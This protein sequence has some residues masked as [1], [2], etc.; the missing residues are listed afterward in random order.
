MDIVLLGLSIGMAN[1]LLATGIVL[2]HM[3]GRVIN[4]A[5]GELGAFA[6]AMMLSLTR[7]AHLPYPVA[8]LCSL[9]ATALLAAIIERT[10]VRRLF[11]SPRLI[12]LIGLIGVAQIIVVL[13]LIL[14]KPRVGEDTIYFGGAN[15]FPVPFKTPVW[16]FDRVVLHPQHFMALILGP[17][18]VIALSMFLRRSRYGVALRASAENAT[19][20]RS[21]GIPVQRV[22]TLAWVVAAVL[23]GI[24]SILLAPIVGFSATEAV[25]LPILMRGLAAATLARMQSVRLAF[26]WGLALGVLDQLVF[27]QTGRA[28]LTD[29]VLF[30]IVLIALLVRGREQR[31]TVASE[32]SSWDAAEPVRPLPA[33]ILT[34]PRWRGARL[35]TLAVGALLLLAAPPLLRTSTTFF[36]AA[37][38][39]IATVVVATTVLV[40]W[41]GQLSLGQWALA[42][43]GGVFGA[44]LVADFHVPFP[45][46]FVLAAAMGGLV[47]LLI[48]IPGLRIEGTGLA[49]VTLGFAIM[50]STW[51]YSQGFF[52][53]DAHFQP[54][55]YL[56]TDVHYFASLALLVG[57]FFALRAVQR[58]VLGFQIVA[59][60]DNPRQAAA[61]GVDVRRAQ[62]TAFV[63]SGIVAG[64][65]GFLWTAGTVL[66][67]ATAFPAIRSLSI[68]AAAIIG[69]VG[70]LGG[71]IIGALY[72]WGIPYMTADITPYAGLLAT[73]GGLLGLV[74]F[75]PGGLVRG[76]YV[77][78]NFAAR[79]LTGVDPHPAVVPTSATIPTLSSSEAPT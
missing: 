8:L 59:T 10:V 37:V 21:L 46:A 54:P 68:I 42:G 64:A 11:T 76:L 25:G 56:T 62:L 74:L 49:V 79:W 61:L 35:S 33:A 38:M 1:A 22:S 23:S 16:E 34:H 72:M 52:G 27:F 41:A 70:S 18:L 63:I 31:R 36:F 29:L 75:L 14:P 9:A 40:G 66:A 71:A 69:G 39:L 45:L 73:G 30:A 5:H 12:V 7:V 67:N 17:I 55:S 15:I 19:R 58:S 57:S 13:R 26:A 65:A 3:S 6:V 51:L 43:V 4:M 50:S 48:G 24:A 78:R 28:G 32:E 44:Q 2:I 20:A 47:A 60:R 53:P 77:A